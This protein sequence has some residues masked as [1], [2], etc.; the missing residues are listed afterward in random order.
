MTFG[1]AFGT[2]LVGFFIACAILLFAYFALI[3]WLGNAMSDGSDAQPPNFSQHLQADARSK[4]DR[5]YWLG[6]SESHHMHTAATVTS[7]YTI[8]PQPI[9]TSS[10]TIVTVHIRTAFPGTTITSL[11]TTDQS[12]VLL[13][14]HLENG[15]TVQVTSPDSSAR[16]RHAVARDLQPVPSR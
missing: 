5:I 15:E 3:S 9:Y 13:T 6:P 12:Q 14:F 2:A 10:R 16:I 11:P 8:V 7:T 1:R 4:T